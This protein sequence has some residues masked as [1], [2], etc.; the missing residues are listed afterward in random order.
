MI[1][2]SKIREH[3]LRK[4]K[5]GK[6]QLPDI[7]KKGAEKIILDFE[8]LLMKIVSYKGLDAHD[9]PDM[10]KNFRDVKNDLKWSIEPIL[11]AKKKRYPVVEEV[12]EDSD[13]DTRLDVKSTKRYTF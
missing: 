12:K 5:Q 9:V 13:G 8:D 3:I 10:L 7:T 2:R 1:H 11:A 6:K 4:A